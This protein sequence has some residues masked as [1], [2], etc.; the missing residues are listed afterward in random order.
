M[1]QAHDLLDIIP[2]LT[3]I[4]QQELCKLLK[5]PI[6]TKY[7]KAVGYAAVFEQAELPLEQLHTKDGNV[8]FLLKLAYQKGI[9]HTANTVLNYT[10]KEQDNGTST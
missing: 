2:A 4:E 5:N 10:P 9:M 6:L 3:D 8:E 7:F 1:A